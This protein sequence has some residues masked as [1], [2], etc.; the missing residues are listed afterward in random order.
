NAPA[1]VDPGAP[2]QLRARALPGK[3]RSL[4]PRIGARAGST[5]RTRSRPLRLPDGAR[6]LKDGSGGSFST[7]LSPAAGPRWS[8]P[9]YDPITKL[10]GLDSVRRAL[11][12][13]GALQPGQRVLDLGCGTGTLVVQLKLHHPDVDVVGVD[14]DPEAHARARRKSAPASLPNS[15]R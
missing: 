2:A 12:G 14:P 11:L 4:L 1:G 5:D 15:T 8:L 3:L 10:L 13:Q 6:A 7:D 9:L